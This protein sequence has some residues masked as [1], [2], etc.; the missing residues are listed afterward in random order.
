V[1][2]LLHQWG[3]GVLV[4]P[5][6]LAG[7]LAAWLDWRDAIALSKALSTPPPP[8]QPEKLAPARDWAA[9]ALQRLRAELAA[10]FA[11]RQLIGEADPKP[12][13][14]ASLSLDDALAPYRLHHAQQQRLLTARVATLRERLRAKLLDCGGPLARLAELDAVMDTALAPRERQAQA[15]LAHQL[16]QLAAALHPAADWPQR[17]WAQLQQALAAEL[18]LRLQPVHG[19]IEALQDQE[20]QA[21]QAR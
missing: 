12:A 11:D 8:A 9:A 18:E 5:P 17:L 13:P 14:D 10:S 19:L 21:A 16:P 3:Q 4:T 6:P 7:Q 1:Q 15:A 20:A 2:R